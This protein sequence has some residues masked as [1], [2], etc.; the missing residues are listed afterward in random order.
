MQPRVQWA[1]ILLIIV[2]ISIIVYA[3]STNIQLQ[4]QASVERK[5]IINQTK[6]LN[7]TDHELLLKL[8]RQHQTILN[9]TEEIR[10]ILQNNS[11]TH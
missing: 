5:I 1:I 11:K 4:Q 3:A 2:G 6:V 9:T 7:Q 10:G 8:T